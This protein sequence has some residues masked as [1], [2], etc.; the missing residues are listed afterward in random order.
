RTRS[1]WNT[2]IYR[3]DTSVTSPARAHLE[4]VPQQTRDD[5]RRE[6][7][8]FR[9]ANRRFL[10]AQSLLGNSFLFHPSINIHVTTTCTNSGT[11]SAIHI[12]SRDSPCPH[13]SVFID[14]RRVSN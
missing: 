1:R 10:L 3:Q 7:R 8:R 13:V 9:H 11:G 12:A 4:A 2:M 6:N 14:I 5:E